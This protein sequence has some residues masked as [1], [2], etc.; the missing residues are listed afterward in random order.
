MNAGEFIKP[1]IVEDY[2]WHMDCTYKGDRMAKYIPSIGEMEV[3]NK[4]IFSPVGS[5]S[6][7]IEQFI[8]LTSCGSKMEHQKFHL[9]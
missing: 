7:P 3:S 6:R 2:S 8:I 9:T 1:A 5:N 4:K